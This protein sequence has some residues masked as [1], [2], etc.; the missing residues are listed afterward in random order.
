MSLLSKSPFFPG[1]YGSHSGKPGGLP[2]A[3]N[4]DNPVHRA[5]HLV[6]GVNGIA[7]IVPGN[8]FDELLR[9][10]HLSRA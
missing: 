6:G 5:I 4:A 2:S 8:F 7:A 10:L 9:F 1:T 3:Q